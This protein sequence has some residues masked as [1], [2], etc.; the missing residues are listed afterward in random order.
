MNK[1]WK[2]NWTRYGHAFLAGILKGTYH[3]GDTRF[4]D[5]IILKTD[6]KE[7]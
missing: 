6:L 7:T 1:S 3:Y 5:A 2:I 4:H